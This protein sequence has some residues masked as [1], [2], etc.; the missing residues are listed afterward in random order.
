MSTGGIHFTA[1]HQLPELLGI[2]IENNINGI[3]DRKYH[4]AINQ[5]GSIIL[6]NYRSASEIAPIFCANGYL[7]IEMESLHSP[8]T[9]GTA[10]G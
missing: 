3:N 2:M 7:F 9:H 6:Q 5:K 8:K 4:I 10:P 1:T